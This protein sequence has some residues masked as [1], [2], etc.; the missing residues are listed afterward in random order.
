MRAATITFPALLG[1]VSLVLLYGACL[2]PTGVWGWTAV[3]G[4]AP[5]AVVASK[6]VGPGFLCW[7]GA[8]L[9][10][11]LLLPDKF[12]AVL[13]ALLFGL[14]PMG[15][16]LAERLKNPFMRYGAKLAFF[17]VSLSLLLSFMRA[18]VLA[19]LPDFAADHA[20]VLL[21]LIG[22]IV[23][24][25]YDVGLTRLI[26]FYLARVDRAVRKNGRFG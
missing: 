5:L 14:Y 13:Y 22:N 23:F 19:S 18:L 15:K 16:A 11:I 25:I 17:N 21:Y 24:L 2:M 20:L 3:A 1:A 26:R 12:C 4:L 8:S 10:G 6:G 7:G 9:L